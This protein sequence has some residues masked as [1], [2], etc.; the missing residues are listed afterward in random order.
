MYVYIHAAAL[1]A[2]GPAVFVVWLLA[3][4]DVRLVCLY[5]ACPPPTHTHTLREGLMLDVR[6]VSLCYNMTL[7]GGVV[8][9]KFP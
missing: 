5:H 7:C 9:G 1:E 2:A 8:T 6:Q 4:V 3:W